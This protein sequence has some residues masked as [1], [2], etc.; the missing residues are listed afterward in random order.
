MKTKY[1][2]LLL[3]LCNLSVL[4]QSKRFSIDLSIGTGI[5][6]E[7]NQIYNTIYWGS[8]YNLQFSYA[9]ST[10]GK[11]RIAMHVYAGANTTYSTY[12]RTQQAFKN[13]SIFPVPFSIPPQEFEQYKDGSITYQGVGLMYKF[14][15][16]QRQ[17]ISL[18]AGLGLNYLKQFY[19]S[20]LV[21]AYY[22]DNSQQVVYNMEMRRNSSASIVLPMQLESKYALNERWAVGILVGTFLNVYH[23]VGNIQIAPTIAYAF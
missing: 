22:I 17:K 6:R 3:L 15:F 19:S 12:E 11:H 23:E 13:P 2:C 10:S 5:N 7:F 14:R 21:S 20:L 8:A 18:S 9:T 4:A 16:L 1:L